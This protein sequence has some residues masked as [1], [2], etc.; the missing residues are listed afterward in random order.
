MSGRSRPR[1]DT[2]SDIDIDIDIDIDGDIDGAGQSPA[3]PHGPATAG[4]PR[5]TARRAAPHHQ[6]EETA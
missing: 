1:S 6:H 2:A 5:P 3:P 4:R